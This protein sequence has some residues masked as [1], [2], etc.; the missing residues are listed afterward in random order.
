MIDFGKS[1]LR[2]I[3]KDFKSGKMAEDLLKEKQKNQIKK[4]E[5]EESWETECKIQELR[6]KRLERERQAKIEKENKIS[7]LRAQVME[8][9]SKKNYEEAEK[10]EEEIKNIRKS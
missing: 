6:Q 9:K 5:I 1:M 3:V 7:E 4:G 2:G 8:L 10:L